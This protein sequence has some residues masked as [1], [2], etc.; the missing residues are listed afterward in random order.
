MAA[1]AAP[2]RGSNGSGSRVTITPS[3][4]SILGVRRC[5]TTDEIDRAF[6]RLALTRHPDK[7]G[8]AA[9]FQQLRRAHDVLRNPRQ[10]AIYD[11]CGPSMRPSPGNTIGKS[12]VGRLIPLAV[13]AAS[14]FLG[15]L[16]WVWGAYDVFGFAGATAAAAGAGVFA[17]GGHSRRDGALHASLAGILLGNGLAAA[18]ILSA[19]GARWLLRG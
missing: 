4:Y 8:D 10:R 18:A 14:G 1:A 2:H 9:A 3:Y 12:T 16:G 11:E 6:K 13:S 15:Q 17:G 19:R 5:A 7:G